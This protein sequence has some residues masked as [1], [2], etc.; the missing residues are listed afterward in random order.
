VLL[1][2]DGGLPRVVHY[3]VVAGDGAAVVAH[4]PARPR[5][6]TGRARTPRRSASTRSCW[7]AAPC[8][9]RRPEPRS[10][11]LRHRPVHHR[12]RRRRACR[13]QRG[14]PGELVAALAGPAPIQWAAHPPTDALETSRRAVALL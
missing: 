10:C 5:T 2:R 9:P 1:E 13:A 11:S 6:R 3:A 7:R 14:D 12:P 4:A 8:W